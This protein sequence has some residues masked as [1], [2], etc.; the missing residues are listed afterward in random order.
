MSGFSVGILTSEIVFIEKKV[1]CYVIIQLRDYSVCIIG[2]LG[3]NI[4][5]VKKIL[6]V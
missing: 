6:I 5:F 1:V 2:K 3:Q 4:N